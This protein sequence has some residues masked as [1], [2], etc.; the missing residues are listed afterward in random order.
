MMEGEG[1]VLGEGINGP[2]RKAVSR[3][4]G[5]K[6]AVKTIS[7][8]NLS[9]QRKQMVVSELRI[10][11]QVHHRNIVQLL[12]VYESER[13]VL[14]VMEVCT[15]GELFERLAKRKFYTEVD[16]AK[17]TGQMV[18]A[19]SY[20]HANNICHRELKLQNWLYQS[21]HDDAN[22]MLCDFG[23]GQVSGWDRNDP[24]SLHRDF[25]CQSWH[26]FCSFFMC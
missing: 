18:A 3:D 11:R 22:L 5:R 6:A 26:N 23:F 25:F 24:K 15:G 4:D 19:V 12:E 10:F 7:T 17:V 20:L 14:L 8:V 9:E 13:A 16:A 21:D 1:S 2:V